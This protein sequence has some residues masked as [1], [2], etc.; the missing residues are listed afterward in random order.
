MKNIY[1]VDIRSN[2]N[3]GKCTGHFIP[4]ARNFVDIFSGDFNVKVAAGPTYQ[5]AFPCEQILPLPY[6]IPSDERFWERIKSKVKSLWNCWVLFKSIEPNSCLIWQHSTLLTSCI[7]IILFGWVKP[8]TIHMILYSA[9]SLT[10]RFN[11]TLFRMA[12]K[13]ISSILCPNHHVG[14]ASKLPYHVVPDYVY[15]KGLGKETTVPFEEKKYDFCFV[16]R[17]NRDKGVAEVLRVLRNQQYR[18][19]VAGSPDSVAYGKELEALVDGCTNISLRLGFI[20]TKQYHDY[21]TYSRYSI[22]NYQGEYSLRSSGVVYD[23]LF[24]GVPVIGTKCEALRMVEEFS[25]GYLYDNLALVD[26][27]QFLNAQRHQQF[28]EN[29]CR[30]RETHTAYAALLKKLVR[31]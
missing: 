8:V 17:F 20:E 22:L 15:V 5:G 4:V 24:A 27:A 31:G 12:G 2:N 23:T 10:S 1:I 6:S 30:Y 21:I 11:A 14:R 7:G 25:L 28:L 19:I 16:G 29:I 26:W 13:R 18:V 3:R 9:D